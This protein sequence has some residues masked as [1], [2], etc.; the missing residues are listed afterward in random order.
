MPRYK[1]YDYA[2][3]MM[4]PVSLE[5][6][7]EPGTLEY[8]IHHLIEERLD[9]SIFDDRYRND[10]TGRRAYDPKVL[11]KVVLFA[12]ARGILHS[13]RMERACRENVTFMALTCGQTPDHST[14]AAFIS[15]MGE[16]RVVKLFS[17]VLLICEAE[18]LLGGTHFSLDGCKLKGNASKEWSGTRAELEKKQAK[19]EA[20]VKQAVREHRAAD[21]RGDDPDGDRRA[22]RVRRL[23]QQAER[24]GQFLAENEAKR[25]CRGKEVQ[26]NVTDPESA[27]M[28]SSHGV[29]QGYN[30]NA[31]VDGKRQVVV[32]AEAFGNGNDASAMEP[33]LAGAQ[34]NL[35]AAG[36][37]N[38][39]LKDKVVSADT[40]YFSIDNLE[41]CQAAEVD[42][43][44]PDRAFRSRDPRF[45]EA[46]R[47]RRSV[48]KHKQKY[49]SK[50]RW[51]GPQDFRF[52]DRTKTLTCPAGH[53]LYK[54]GNAYE[55][56]G[57]TAISYKA[58]KRACRDC[59]LRAKCL[60]H[61]HTPARQVRLFSNK[62]PGSI[63][64]AMR[65]KI[66]TQEGRRIYGKRLAHVEPVFANLREQKRMD[67]FTVR[68]RR[69][70]NVQW[71]LYCLVHNIEK[72]VHF[73]ERYAKAS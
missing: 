28:T 10:E 36:L 21:E 39:A 5:H 14:L 30:A 4:I 45:A 54:N 63:T 50:R 71:T 60:R 46:R 40:G 73:G 16:E 44:V 15:S 66:D 33:M 6:Q 43:Y 18:G 23:T 1:P 7:L 51:F 8:A 68:G 17:E 67:R 11:L 34:R 31:L 22:K 37:G 72:I 20:K 3:L 58:P 12:Y 26:S 52:D 57:Y 38:E 2:Q 64:D 62:R 32:H 70:V 24:I 48:D 25:G 65:T 53:G 9:T 59:P 55:C 49:K 42:A 27:K 69:K 61:P 41:A 35:K 29:L 19:L 13:R 56:H 47:H